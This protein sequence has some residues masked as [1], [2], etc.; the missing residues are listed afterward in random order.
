MSTPNSTRDRDQV[1]P[2]S[3]DS[4]TAGI[5]VQTTVPKLLLTIDQLADALALSGK[6][7]YRLTRDDGLPAIRFGRAVRYRLGDV[8]KWLAERSKSGAASGLNE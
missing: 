5:V 1:K 8:E 4:T 6:T 7:I 2:L 3:L